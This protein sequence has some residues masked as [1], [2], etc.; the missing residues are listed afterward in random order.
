[1][2]PQGEEGNLLSPIPYSLFSILYTPIPH[3]LSPIPYFLKEKNG[4]K[5]KNS[6]PTPKD[7]Q[8]DV[9]CPDGNA[10]DE[11]LQRGA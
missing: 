10:G 9:R 11:Y 7:D 5:E 1:M 6:F 4:N 8:P 3:F 2:K